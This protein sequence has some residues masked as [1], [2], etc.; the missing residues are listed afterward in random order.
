MLADL[1]EKGRPIWRKPEEIPPQPLST[2]ELVGRQE[3]GNLLVSGENLQ[4]LTSLQEHFSGTVQCVYIDPPFNAHSEFSHYRD[5]FSGDLW[6]ELM[7]PRL[8]KIRTLMRPSGLIFVHIDHR[9]LAQLKL[10]MDDIFGAKNFVSLVT[11]KV[12]DPAGVGQQSLLFDVCEYLLVYSRDP[13]HVPRERRSLSH[14]LSAV[15]GPV[16]GYRKALVDPGHS[17]LVKT[18]K[19]RLVGEIK[20]HRCEGYRIKV[21]DRS[22]PY[23]EYLLNFEKIFADYNPSGGTINQIKNEIPA[24]GLSFIEYVPQKGRGAGKLTKVYFLNRRILAW[25]RDIASAD[26]QGRIARKA[27]LTNIWEVATAQLFAEG[28]VDFR[29]GKKPEALLDRIISLATV[30][31]DLVLDAFLG[32]GTTAAVAHKLGR[33]WIGI[34]K[35]PA[36]RTHAFAR[37]KRV[38]SGA[39]RTGISKQAGWKGGGG[40]EFCGLG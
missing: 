24:R 29:Q 34:E 40:F 30:P 13:A 16:K 27:K 5:E 21:F 36:V 9:E 3:Q 37:L 25:L 15:S 18:V 4:A 23:E 22:T 11:V 39:D 1:D 28:G 14:D 19:R 8:E 26:S 7:R 35:E 10:L 17:E 2:I 20:I 38:V 6:L 32:S 31:G 33:R 12:K